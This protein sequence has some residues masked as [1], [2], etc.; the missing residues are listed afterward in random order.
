MTKNYKLFRYFLFSILSWY[1]LI[2]GKQP[3]N[4]TKI[5]KGMIIFILT[6]L[7]GT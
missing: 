3:V 5:K 2:R 7:L 1:L 4:P 6:V